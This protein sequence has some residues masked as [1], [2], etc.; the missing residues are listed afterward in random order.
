MKKVFVTVLM[1]LVTFTMFASH[2]AVLIDFTK[3]AADTEDGQN[4]ATLINLGDYVDYSLSP[5]DKQKL[6]LSFSIANWRVVLDPTARNTYRVN[7]SQVREAVSKGGIDTG[8]ASGP[9][10][11]E[12]TT[13]MGFR[14][15]FPD[16]ANGYYA[17]IT[18]PSDIPVYYKNEAGEFIFQEGRGVIMNIGFIKSVS[19]SFNGR[20]YPM[21]LEI[22]LINQNREL[23]V[24]PM[25]ALDFLGWKNLSWVN[26]Q[27]VQEAY[28]RDVNFGPVYPQSIP[29]WKLHSVRIRKNAQFPGGNFIGYIKDIKVVY[30]QAVVAP[31]RNIDD[32]EVWQIREEEGMFNTEFELRK[33]ARQR[34]KL[35]LEENRMNQ[36]E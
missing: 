19:V 25:G 29:Y 13:V 12:D 28:N 16:D 15:I 14:A 35:F 27:Y 5:A 9:V 32:E 2:E 24:I 20:N 31:Y 8:L 34:V 10:T 26:P 18:P 6:F 4:S 33:L 3:F 30:D 11:V 21:N 22:I 1:F 36:G 7:K 23:M 17:D